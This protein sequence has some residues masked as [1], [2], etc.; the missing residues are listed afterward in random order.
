MANTFF[1]IIK[2]LPNV[3]EWLKATPRGSVCEKTIIGSNPI[4]RGN[5]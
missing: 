2:K 1:E 5:F 3:A 4:I